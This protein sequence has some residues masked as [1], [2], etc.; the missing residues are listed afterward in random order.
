MLVYAVPHWDRVGGDSC[1][2]G[3]HRLGYASGPVR[4]T[5]RLWRDA[6]AFVKQRFQSL[7]RRRIR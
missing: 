6:H 2:Q 3:A 7:H 5:D 1:D 4:L